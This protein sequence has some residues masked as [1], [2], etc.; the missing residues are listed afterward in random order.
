M[1]KIGQLVLRGAVFLT[2]FLFVQPFHSQTNNYSRQTLFDPDSTIPVDSEITIGQLKN[3]LTYYIRENSKPENRAQLWLVVNAGSILEDDDQI[4]LAHFTEHMAFNGTRHFKKHEIINFLESVGMKFG[5]EVNAYTS[6]DETVYML[7]VPTMNPTVIEKGIQILEDWAHWV[8]FAD[9]EIERERGIVIEEWRLGRGADI[10]MFNKQLP[11]IF[12]DSRYA[13]RLPI[14]K[15]EVLESFHPE[16]LKRFYKEWYRPDLMCII[17]V[18]DFDKLWMESLIKKYFGW[19]SGPKNPRPRENYLMPDH[20]ETLIAIATDPEA[21]STGVAVYYK[22]DPMPIKTIGDFKRILMERIFTTMLNS[23]L[24]EQINQV[25]PPYLFGYSGKSRFVRLKSIYSLTAGIKEDGI[26]QGLETLVTEAERIKLH[27]F[28][29]SELER[30]KNKVLRQIEKAYKESDKTRSLLFARKCVAHFLKNDPLPGLRYEYEMASLLMPEI[31]NEEINKLA[32]ELMTDINR[33]IL[34][35]APENEDVEIPSNQE[36]IAVFEKVRARPIEPYYDHV[37]EEPLIRNLPNPGEIVHTKIIPQINVTEWTLSNGVKV[38]LKPTSFKNDEIKFQA[39]SPGGNSLI[40]D[41]NFM[42]ANVATDIIRESGLGSFSL[43]ELNKK[44]TGK[45]VSVFPYIN[46][47]SEGLLGSSSPEDVETMFQLIYLYMSAPRMDPESF[48]SYRN[49]MKGFFE[50][51]NG[52][53]E[54]AFYD[55][56]QVTLGQYHFRERPWSEALMDEVDL[57]ILYN[58]YKDRFSDASD[59]TFFF[60]GNFELENIKPL[61]EI[62]L[63]GLTSTNRNET[64]KDPGISPP[65]GVISKSV[66]KGIEPKSLVRLI[67]SGPMEWS[68]ENSH[69]LKS[70]ASIL[71]IRLRETMREKLSGTYGVRVWAASSLYPREEY[72]ISIAFGCSPDRVD[73][74]LQSLFRQINKLKAKGP[75]EVYLTKVREAQHREFEINLKEN[76]FWVQS[77]LSIYFTDQDPVNI[78]KYP[79]LIDS[80]T[81]KKIRQAAREYFNLDNYIQVVLKPEN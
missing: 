6:F 12:K 25:N 47:L 35:N 14:G 43:P 39:F 54:S 80:L 77:L 38:V 78:M 21:T 45:L 27:G 7:Q 60:V 5:P 62:Y 50:N 67:F 24:Y 10:R 72:S 3:G 37:S 57:E 19:F 15:K 58:F 33:V 48:L 32:H 70:L 51:R 29:S 53:P 26:I 66:E 52:S 8:N 4:G 68:Y 17:A 44:L 42:S 55:T 59:F 63:G 1:G 36:L 30:T 74:L 65:D 13:S 61:I 16:A 20:E 46:T 76:N 11:V 34:L 64:W 22:Y 56:I 75:D 49:R 81:G 2:I 18:G 73:E 23:R 40:N 41:R 69:T 9:E 79:Q 71:R 28:T 31:K